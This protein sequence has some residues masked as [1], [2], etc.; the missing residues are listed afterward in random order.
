MILTTPNSHCWFFRLAKLIGLLKRLQNPEHLHFFNL[1]DMQ[2]LFSHAELYGYFPYL[3]LRCTIR[4]GLSLLT[5]TFVIK[6]Q[7]AR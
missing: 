3:L 6:E 7:K 4:R 1:N 2:K 5:P